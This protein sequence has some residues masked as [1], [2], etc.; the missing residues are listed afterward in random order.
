MKLLKRGRVN[1]VITN[2]VLRYSYHKTPSLDGLVTYGEVELPKDTIKDGTIIDKRQFQT[3]VEQLVKTHNWKRKQLYFCVPDD[4]VV[5]RQLKIPNVLSHD[6]A[7]AYVRTQL[8]RNIYLPFDNPALAIEWLDTE[9]DNREILLFAYPKGKIAAYE[10]AFK[11][12]GLKPTAADLTA[13]SIYR[14]YY[15]QIHENHDHILLI[16]WNKDALALTAFQHHK[17]IFT[18]YMKTDAGPEMTE[19]SV[20]HV[21]DE[22][23][24][25]INRIIDFYHFSITKGESRIQML[26]LTG[27]SPFLSSVY[28]SLSETTDLPIYNFN[29]TELKAKYADVLGLALKPEM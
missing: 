13:L 17:E 12:A 3:I 18:R 19:T 10:T 1:I 4:T 20:R 11:D 25:E 22:F 5:I 15:V 27:D 26:L 2:H 21:I 24:V 28:T 29:E 6:E 7:L 9:G 23:M 14:N 16:H 8:G